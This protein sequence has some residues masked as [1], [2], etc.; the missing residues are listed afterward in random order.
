MKIENIR[1]FL[2][3]SSCGNFNR[4]AENLNVAQSTV[5]ARVKSME[6]VF[7]RRLFKRGHAGVELTSA[8]QHFRQYALNIQRL[9][10]Q[11]HQHITLPENFS[12][13]IGLGSQVSLWDSLILKWIPWMRRNAS[14]IALHVEADYSPSLM[15]Q[16]SDGLLDIGVMYQPRQTPGLVVEDLFEETLVLVTTDQRVVIEG[17]VEGYVFVDWGDVFRV[18]H[19]EAFPEMETPAV[20]V[21]LG[22]LGLEYILQNSGSGYFPVRVVQPYIEQARLFRIEGTPSVQRPAYMVYPSSGRNP[23][24][25]E[26]ALRGLRA[27]VSSQAG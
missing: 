20:S 4:A 3:I 6:Q 12:H 16:L 23:E 7:G 15:R 24:A 21:G 11:A 18:R 26:L 1:T 5:S 27:I 9:W 17:W 22:A 25:L 13:S 14:D 2:E 8:G 10:Q 19:A